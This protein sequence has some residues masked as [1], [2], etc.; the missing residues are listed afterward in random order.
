MSI[1]AALA[2]EYVDRV[3]KLPESRAID[4]ANSQTMKDLNLKVV[5]CVSTKITHSFSGSP[6]GFMDA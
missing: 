1:Q 4:P 3:K 5:N 6:D 2:A